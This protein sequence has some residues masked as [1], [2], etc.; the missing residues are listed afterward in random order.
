MS[1][2]FSDT[3]SFLH[4]ELQSESKCYSC[5]PGIT[6][7]CCFNQSC[8]TALFILVLIQKFQMLREQ[9]LIHSTEH[10]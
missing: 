9:A 3:A 6:T 8:G 2:V 7:L 1:S 4:L 5:L 10:M